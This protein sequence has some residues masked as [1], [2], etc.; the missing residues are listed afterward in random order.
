VNA[1]LISKSGI[2][3]DSNVA[4]MPADNAMSNPEAESGAEIF[5][6]GVKGIEDFADR[7]GRNSADANRTLQDKPSLVRHGVIR[8]KDTCHLCRAP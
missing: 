6:C 8:P 3:S 2:A 1:S 7:F 5:F 4:A